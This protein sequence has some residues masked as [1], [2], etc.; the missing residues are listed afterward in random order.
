MGV[1]KPDEISCTPGIGDDVAVI[2]LGEIIDIVPGIPGHEIIAGTAPEFVIAVATVDL[3]IAGESR[4]EVVVPAG[5]DA[6]SL[7]TALEIVVER[8]AEE[9]VLPSTVAPR[10]GPEEFQE[11][12]AGQDGVAELKAPDAVAQDIACLTQGNEHTVLRRAQRA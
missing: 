5:V 2:T 3:V 11:L 12:I 4:D 1:I 10:H 7:S 6:V 9:V 8:R